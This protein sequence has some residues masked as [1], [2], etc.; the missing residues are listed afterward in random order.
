MLRPPVA[1]ERIVGELLQPGGQAALERMGLAEATDAAA[2]D[3]IRVD[4]YVV[5]TPGGSASSDLLLTYPDGVPG[6]AAEHLGFVDGPSARPVSGM[7]P[8]EGTVGP[9]GRPCGSGASKQASGTGGPPRGRSFW[10]HH[11]VHQLRHLARAEPLVDYRQGSVRSLLTADADELLPA[12]ADA[13][14]GLCR[15]VRYVTA[16]R[17]EAVARAPLVVLADGMFSTMRKRLDGGTPKPSSTFVGYL[18]HHPADK[19]CVP[20]PNRGHVVLADPNPVL[21]YQITPTVTRILVDVPGIAPSD[22]EDWMRRYMEDRIVAQLPAGVRPAFLEALR[23]QEP[24]SCVNKRLPGGEPNVRRACLLGDAWNMRHPLTGGGMTVALRDVE[25]LAACLQDTDLADEA[26]LAASLGEFRRRRAGHATT[27]NVLANALHR[28]F[29]KPDADDG[30]RAAL[31]EA[32]IQY[33]KLGGASSAG[34][35][36][37]LAALT[38]KPLVLVSHFVLVALFAIR[39]AVLPLPTPARV[40]QSWRLM[41]VACTILMPLA[42]AENVAPLSWGPVRWALDL[43]FPWSHV[44]VDGMA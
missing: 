14:P 20:Y 18:L 10:N 42:Q 19:P 12:D 2:I 44:D 31:R 33:L 41:Q 39:N 34:P 15:G 17:T 35:V 43:V 21:L 32:C 29:T 1:Q 30:T 11:F 4:G 7:R 6:S 26:A 28:V 37:L 9:D 22:D 5:I 13:D 3:S 23:T 40:M 38:P 8:G 25:T 27:V 16:D 24:V 36:G